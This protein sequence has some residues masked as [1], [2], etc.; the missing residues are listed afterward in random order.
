MLGLKLRSEFQKKRLKHTQIELEDIHEWTAEGF[1][2]ITYPS[3]DLLKTLEALAP[4]EGRPVVLIGERGKGKSHLMVA[5]H[6]AIQN[7]SVL[8]SWLQ[9]WAGQLGNDRIASLQPR[10]NAEVIS[11]NLNR[12]KYKYLWD[13]I[14]EQHPEG[15][16]IRGKWEGMGDK[17]TDIL[18]YELILELLRKQPIVLILDEFQTWYDAL[19]NTK[20]LP[21]RHWAFSFIQILS[22][23]AKEYPDLLALVVSVRNGSTE[24]YQQIHRVNP[25]SIDFKSP[26]AAS[27]RRKLLLH[28]LFENRMQVPEQDINGVTEA[29][30]AEYCRLKAVTPTDQPRRRQEFTESWPFAPHL[31]QLLEDQVLVA[32]EAQETRDLIKILADL[33]KRN[34]DNPLITAADFRVDDE[35]SGIASLLDSVASQHHRNLREKAQRNLAAVRDAVKKPDHEVPHLSEIIGALW[36]R[37][38]SVSNLT[39]AD[40]V[41]LQI[42]ITRSQPIDE[43]AFQVELDTIADNSFNIHAQG[44]RLVFLEEENAQTKLMAYAR[45]D[46]L[47]TD[48]SD[49]LHLRSE[50][51]YAVG[52]SGDV[53]RDFRVI[54]L[55]SQWLSDPWGELDPLDHPDQWDARLPILVVPEEL[56]KLDVRLGTWLKE[57]VPKY[58]NTIRFLLPK[59]GS[60]NAYRDRDLVVLSRAV[61][62]AK[63]WG[64]EYKKLE[65]KYHKQLQEVLQGRF[66]RFAILQIWNYTE[67]SR[68]QFVVESLQAKGDKIPAAIE[69]RLRRDIFIPEDFEEYVLEAAANSDSVGKLLREL[70]E[71]RPGGKDCIPWL[72]EVQTKEKLI[73]LCTQGKIAINLRGMETLQAK[74]GEDEDAAWHR[75]KGKL[76]TGKHLD[77]TSLLLPQAVPSSDGLTSSSGAPAPQPGTQPS[78]FNS[79]QSSTAVPQ[80]ETGGSSAATASTPGATYPNPT[81][82]NPTAHENGTGTSTSSGSIFDTAPP[83]QVS[84]R[85]TPATSALNLYAKATDEWGI[86]PGSQVTN[87]TISVD[88]LTGAQLQKLLKN[89]PD[90]LTYALELDKEEG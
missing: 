65:R 22:E 43:N 67:P 25:V 55:P 31:L 44:D 46:R 19:T 80:P 17:K 86:N 41:T 16:F 78:L 58:R 53:Q 49:R 83:A 7:P 36:L 77:E 29:H 32:T 81:D 26:N 10:T 48:G 12:Q 35:A 5:L 47:F 27:E 24:A 21:A 84:R 52:G 87:V 70:Q 9:F 66:D 63:E 71:P 88:A 28:R 64:P 56:D 73:R 2:A 42:D 90:G 34:S 15:D 33:F 6:H 59:A 11:V 62:K 8:S 38:L 18:P 3:T 74:P 40:P 75:M 82:T 61:L 85:S 30:V 89:L 76:P 14:L 1:L 57:H 13:L 54:V 37:S 23:I 4:G 79:G 72:G 39:G 68:C 45:N 60:L 20:R 50:I 51:R 69:D